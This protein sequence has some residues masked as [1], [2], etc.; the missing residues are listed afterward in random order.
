MTT[1]AMISTIVSLIL[2]L[3][4]WY[5]KSQ[6]DRRYHEFETVKQRSIDNEKHLEKNKALD[7]ADKE[8]FETYRKVMD[9]KNRDFMR[10]LNEIKTGQE[11]LSAKVQAI[12]EDVA[13]IKSKIGP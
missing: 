10:L 11:T 13:G 4:I 6:S 8:A 7:Q 2:G 9:D 1:E 3:I 5:I 12:A